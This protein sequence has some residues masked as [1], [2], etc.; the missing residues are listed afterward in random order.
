VSGFLRGVELKETRYYEGGDVEVDVEVRMPALPARA[1]AA[2]MREPASGGAKEL[3]LVEKG[4]GVI[5]E[6]EW[7]E[8]LGAGGDARP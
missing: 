6:S 5:S 1:G 8:I 7:R 4:G 2:A 3:L